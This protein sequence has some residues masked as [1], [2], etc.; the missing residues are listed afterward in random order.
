MSQSTLT[1]RA[2]Q[3]IDVLLPS[4]F[5]NMDVAVVIANQNREIVM[6]NGAAEAL[7]E[8]TEQELLGRK[9]RF[10]YESVDDFEEQ[11]RKRFNASIKT[12][13]TYITNYRKKS[14]E[15]FKG[16][17]QGGPIQSDQGD[18]LFFVGIVKDVTARLS[19]T[20]TLNKLHSIT[21]S[22]ETSFDQR[23]LQILTLGCQHFGMPIGIFSHISDDIYTVKKAVHPKNAL[24]EGM[25]FELGATYCSHV[26]EADNVQGFHH[27]ANSRIKTHPCYKNFRLEAYLGAPII[28]DGERYGTLNF[29]SPDPTR[30]F[31]DQD[32]ELIRLFADWIGSEILRNEHLSSLNEAQ[33]RL[34]RLA[35]TDD[36]TGLWNR[37]RMKESLATEISKFQRY[38]SDLSISIIDFD[39]FKTINDQWGHDIGDKALQAFSQ[40]VSEEARRGDLF[41]R[42]GG[43]EF[44]AAFPSTNSQ[45]ALAVLSRIADR[46]KD[47]SLTDT[48]N[49]PKLTIS[50]GIVQIQE[51]EN[52]SRLIARADA[53]MYEAKNSGRDRIIIDH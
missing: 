14:G 49:N 15:L 26:F 41:A 44:L 28:V 22:Q 33:I 16:E 29:S 40:I 1:N 42:W 27:V 2:R 21:S 5:D 4:I 3:N 13:S 19:A 25:T 30:P 45:D 7:F 17:T 50:A 37:R 23:V 6:A 52:L 38:N 32:I 51:G 10:L 34:E 46:L 11:G 20:E 39:H 53:A 36:L 9:T 24:T 35:N 31:I 47:L 8:Y 48:G 18:N 43:E 12:T